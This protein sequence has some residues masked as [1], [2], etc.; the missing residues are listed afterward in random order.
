MGILAAP[1]FDSIMN[2]IADAIYH[3]YDLAS[4]TGNGDIMPGD[5]IKWILMIP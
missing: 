2:Q 3:G 4:T 1:T 5:D